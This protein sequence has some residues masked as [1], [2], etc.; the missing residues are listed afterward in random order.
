MN[1]LEKTEAKIKRETK[2]FTKKINKIC[3]F[4]YFQEIVVGIF[5]RN[6]TLWKKNKLYIRRCKN[7]IYLKL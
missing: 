4:Q 7:H 5:S 2:F 3:N 6:V 1:I